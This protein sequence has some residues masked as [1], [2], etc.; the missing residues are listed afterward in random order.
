MAA[1]RVQYQTDLAP[2][3]PL[4]SAITC[5][6]L[7][8]VLLNLIIN[9]IEAMD[10]IEGRPRDLRISSQ[11][12]K[13]DGYVLIAVEDSGAGLAPDHLDRI[14]DAF[15]S[16]KPEG[17]GMGLSIGRSIIIAHGGRLWAAANP[18]HGATFQF[19]VPI[20]EASA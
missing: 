18:D 6:A 11:T 10:A 14:F 12:Q 1:H 3:L 2:D 17:M 7:Q 16:T 5:G 9:G 4:W 19:T 15:V 20:A 8:Q 13:D